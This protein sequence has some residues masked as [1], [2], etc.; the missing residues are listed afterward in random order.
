[1][2]EFE[3]LEKA[4]DEYFRLQVEKQ[5]AKLQEK[6]DARQELKR[7]LAADKPVMSSFTEQQLLYA[8]RILG[9]RK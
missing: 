7:N 6:W 2:H 4:R 9:L 5:K 1:M 3:L 8:E